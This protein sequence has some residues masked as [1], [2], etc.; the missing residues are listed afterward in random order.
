MLSAVGRPH[1]VDCS[2]ACTAGSAAGWRQHAPQRAQKVSPST[3]G[4]TLFR[5]LYGGT[6]SSA[7]LA[8][9]APERHGAIQNSSM[10]IPAEPPLAPSSHRVRTAA[11]LA[12]QLA[13]QRLGRKLA[14]SKMKRKNRELKTTAPRRSS[15][16]VQ[17]HHAQINRRRYRGHAVLCA[18]LRFSVDM[19]KAGV[20]RVMSSSSLQFCYGLYNIIT[21]VAY[22]LYH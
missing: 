14:V 19:L 15:E 3:T 22:P 5:P 12:A 18:S 6:F 9:A 13:A 8:P 11:R 2:A 16:Q 1:T 17:P 7:K 4:N 21:P 20:S 10:V